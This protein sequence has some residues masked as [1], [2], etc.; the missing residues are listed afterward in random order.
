MCLLWILVKRNYREKKMT[1][2]LCPDCKD[3]PLLDDT[4]ECV[5][6]G[7]KYVWKKGKELV[8]EDLK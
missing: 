6:C 3:H 5:F 2:Y 4:L 8:E 1:R 7:G